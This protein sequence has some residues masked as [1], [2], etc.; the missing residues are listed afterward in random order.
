MNVRVFEE[1]EIYIDINSPVAL[2]VKPTK[3][4]MK[5]LLAENANIKMASF[6]TEFEKGFMDIILGI[7]VRYQDLS[8]ELLKFLVLN[9]GNLAN[10][11]GREI[12]AV[13]GGISFRE[14]LERKKAE[15]P[16]TGEKLFQEKININGYLILLE[17]YTK[18][19][20][21]TLLCREEGKSEALIK[22]KRKTQNIYDA[23]KF[24]EQVKETLES[25]NFSNLRKL[26]NPF[27][28][29]FFELYSV[30]VERKDL[31]KLK[32]LEMEINKLPILL[33]NGKISYEEYKRRIKEIE[34]E[35]GLS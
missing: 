19:D 28:V 6:F 3:D 18:G 12:I 22:A 33:I 34:R 27:E 16:Y 32:N 7:K 10:E 5:F 4:L 29:N 35:I 31:K 24:M 26:F 20:E 17:V 8:R 21:Y 1:D 30:F 13:F 25:R 2:N 15:L 9:I 23:L 11:Y 14:Y